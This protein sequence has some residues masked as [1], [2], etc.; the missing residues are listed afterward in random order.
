MDNKNIYV[1]SRYV[2]IFATPIE[3]SKSKSYEPL[4]IV[5][6]QGA[7]Y[8]SKTY[9][10]ANIEL[11]DTDFWVVTG[12][13]NAQVEHYRKEVNDLRDVVDDVETSVSDAITR[14]ETAEQT[15][16]NLNTE[17]LDIKNRVSDVETVSSNN[18]NS[19]GDINELLLNTSLNE[20]S[21]ILLVGKKG[22]KFSTINSAI[23]KAKTYATT[24]NRVLIFIMPGTYNEEIDLS[25]NNG[26]DLMGSGFQ[27]TIVKFQSVYPKSPIYVMGDTSVSNLTFY[28]IVVGG[29]GD[30]Y[31]VHIEAQSHGGTVG[32]ILFENCKFISQS[33]KSAIGVGAGTGNILFK[34]CV[35]VAY[36]NATIYL[37]NLPTALA[38]GQTLEFVN[39][40]LSTIGNPC[41]VIEDVA[42]INNSVVSKLLLT[43]KN[44]TCVNGGVRYKDKSGT[45][46]YVL[47]SK[48]ITLSYDSYNNNI[49][50][51][52]RGKT[53]IIVGSWKY[54]PASKF[55]A[56]N[57]YLYSMSVQDADKYNWSITK[58]ETYTGVN[59]TSSVSINST[60]YNE[61]ILLDTSTEAAGYYVSVDIVGV[62]KPNTWL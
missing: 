33:T 51:I 43:L 40:E 38:T 37:H 6:Y 35:A 3:W 49:A 46:D 7:S 32:N 26:I 25:D 22:C 13:Y 55:T 10:P 44:I 2:P 45:Y 23:T 34:N 16:S 56:L 12:N 14:V 50:G 42:D 5:T 41:I 31:A 24:S 61:V 39:M 4:T 19:I 52:N 36:N 59:I 27:S 21:N 18:T 9:V 1:G 8:T 53:S 57:G 60:R 28:E 11:T 58:V 29:V 20:Q 47:P 62:P 48:N 54:K 17:V 30:S 15:V